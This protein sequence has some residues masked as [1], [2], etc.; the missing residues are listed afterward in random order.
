VRKPCV[1]AHAVAKQEEHERGE[2]EQLLDH[3]HDARELL[4]GDR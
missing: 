1:S 3:H 2:R 4:V